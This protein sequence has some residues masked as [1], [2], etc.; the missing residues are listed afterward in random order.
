MSRRPESSPEPAPPSDT[1]AKLARLRAEIDR[2]DRELLGGL[3]ER[4]TL[5]Q[6]VGRVK[7]RAGRGV[8]SAARERDLLAALRAANPGPFP[9]VAIEP[10]FREIVSGTRS[11]EGPMRVAY[12]GPEGTF[13]H[14]AARRCFGACAE[15]V[16]VSPIAEIFAAVERGDV[17]HGVAPVENTTQG[18]VTET[19]DT[20]AATEVALC[21]EMLLR[22]S[23]HLVSRSGRLEDVQRVASHPQ[24][25]AQC[26]TWLDRH[27]P[28]IE[29]VE[30]SSTAAAA[31]LAADDGGVAAVASPVAG[32][33]YGLLP[34][35]RAIED[36]RDNTT[37]FLLLGRSTPPRSG[38]DLTSAVFTVRKTQPGAL[39]RLLEPF[40]R[41]GVNLT[42]IQSRP[43]P[44]KP[45][46]YLFFLDLEGHRD[47]AAVRAALADAAVHAHS[48]RV[49]GS[50][51]RAGAAEG[52]A[53]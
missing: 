4:A 31:R 23:Y 9:D 1:D 2:V 15:L 20:L 47:D 45:F 35:A 24:G 38:A 44:G 29:R 27:L 16:A 18:V 53:P 30:T 3:N 41:H 50:F 51:P 46:E 19:F 10:V 7:A 40:A 6:E 25:L 36:R 34:A 11:L 43:M 8:Y 37:R 49:L 26:R 13:A 52:V 12:L 14:E 33:T 21:G 28:G 17:E 22:V 42:S 5:V 48:H 32:E 39:H